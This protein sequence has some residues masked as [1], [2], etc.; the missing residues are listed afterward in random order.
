MK[1]KIKS[2]I[3]EVR[4]FIESYINDLLR[5]NRV[6]LK[7]LSE[8]FAVLSHSHKK[9]IIEDIISSFALVEEFLTN[10]LLQ[11]STEDELIEFATKVKELGTDV[12]I[13]KEILNI[14]ASREV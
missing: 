7:I 9:V 6:T 3:T 14:N 4:A 12:N 8:T 2:D 10:E 5:I 11:N 13:L 1:T